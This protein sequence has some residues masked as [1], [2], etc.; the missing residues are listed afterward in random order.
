MIGRYYF[1]PQ[2]DPWFAPADSFVAAGHPHPL[3]FGD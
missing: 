1:V 2:I 3:S